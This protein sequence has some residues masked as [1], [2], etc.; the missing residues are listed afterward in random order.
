MDISKKKCIFIVVPIK[1]RHGRTNTDPFRPYRMPRSV[2]TKPG[3]HPTCTVLLLCLSTY[4]RGGSLMGN[5]LDAFAHSWICQYIF[6]EAHSAYRSKFCFLL[7]WKCQ[8]GS[9]LSWVFSHYQLYHEFSTSPELKVNPQLHLCS[10]AAP[11]RAGWWFWLMGELPLALWQQSCCSWLSPCTSSAWQAAVKQWF[12][13][14]WD[15]GRLKPMSCT[16]PWSLTCCPQV[17][18]RAICPTPSPAT[19][20][21]WSLQP[22]SNPTQCNLVPKLLP[23]SG[24]SL[25]HV[26]QTSWAGNP[27]KCHHNVPQPAQVWWQGKA[28]TENSTECSGLVPHSSKPISWSISMVPPQKR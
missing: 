13:A 2:L 28:S 19:A 26:S 16:V 25:L 22:K 18:P 17:L 1:E 9:K 27:P 14:D 24:E 12:S 20:S 5:M 10:F 21:S 4:T 15:P 6:W 8:L 11:E 3:T 7:P 23:S